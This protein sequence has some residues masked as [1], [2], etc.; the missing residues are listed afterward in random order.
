MSEV[1]LGKFQS[2]EE[3]LKAYQNLEANYTKKCQLISQLKKELQDIKSQTAQTPQNIQ[4]DSQDNSMNIE[5]SQ[6]AA[7]IR[8][9]VCQ[10][11][12]NLDLEI[13]RFFESYP[14]AKQYAA[15]I[16]EAITAQKPTLV[17]FLAAFVQ[18]LTSKSPQDYLTDPEFLEK[19]VYTNENLRQ[20]FIQSYLD[21]LLKGG[22][23]FTVCG[24]A[25]AIS[26]SPP[27]RPKSLAEARDLAKKILTK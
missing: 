13:Q 10:D 14:Q 20:Y 9:N 3:L 15:L 26:V 23:P 19:F 11:D 12:Y 17:D 25:P 8:D 16:G 22:Q 7:D 5:P 1:L 4:V 6:S 21:G 27:A 18:V 24:Q 2:V